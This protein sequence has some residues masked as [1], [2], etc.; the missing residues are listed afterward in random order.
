MLIRH[1][2]I[3]VIFSIET[4]STHSTIINKG[5]LE[6]DT[7]Y[8]FPQVASI[9]ASFT[10]NCTLVRFRSIVWIFLNVLIKGKGLS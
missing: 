5:I 1:V 2:Y 4:F 10:A 8:V 7:L 3:Q 6:V 9:I